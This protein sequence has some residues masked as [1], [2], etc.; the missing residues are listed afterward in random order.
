MAPY[1]FTCIFCKFKEKCPIS[2]DLIVQKN[3]ILIYRALKHHFA[4]KWLKNTNFNENFT[5]GERQPW[6]T[7]FPINFYLFSKSWNL[8][9]MILKCSLIYYVMIILHKPFIVY[10]KKHFKLHIGVIFSFFLSHSLYDYL[11][12]NIHNYLA[13][14]F[15][16]FD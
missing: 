3:I 6:W 9:H 13:S 16:I 11:F 10:F 1:I 14:Y 2:S 12:L 7:I 15:L 4:T 5:H 8:D